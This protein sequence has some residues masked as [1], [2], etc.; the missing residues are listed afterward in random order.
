MVN[1]FISFVFVGAAIIV[2]FGVPRYASFTSGPGPRPLSDTTRFGMNGQIAPNDVE[3]LNIG[4]YM[5]WRHAVSPSQPNGVEYAQMVRLRDD[6]SDPPYDYW[7]PDW[8]TVAAA[9]A[10]NPG[11]LWLIGNEPDHRGQDNCLASEFASRYHEC[12]TFIKVRDPTARVTPAGIVQATPL[13]LHWLDDVLVAYQTSYGL[14]MPVDAWQMHAQILCETCAWGATYPPGMAE[15]QQSEG[16][17]YSSQDAA[18]V[19]IF[20]EQIVAFR[21]WMRDNGYRDKPLIISEFGVLQPS[22]CGYLGGGDVALGNQMVKDFMTGTFDYCLQAADSAI[23]YPADGDRLVQRWAWYSRNARMSEP[24]CTY[25]TS[26]NG[27]L[28][29]WQELSLLTE[30]GLHFQQYTEGL[31]PTPTPSQTA[32]ATPTITPTVTATPIAAIVGHTTPQRYQ[33][34]GD[35][36]WVTAL[37]VTLS[38]TPGSP[39]EQQVLT[40]AFGV[41]TTTLDVLG[42]TYEIG[43]KGAHTLESSRRDVVIGQGAQHVDFGVLLEGDANDDN[44][45]GILDYSLLYTAFDSSQPSSDFNQDGIVDVLDYSLLYTNY[46]RAGPVYSGS[47]SDHFGQHQNGV[48][49][50]ISGGDVVLGAALPVEIRIFA[51]DAEVDVCQLRLHFAPDLLRVIDDHGS[52]ARTITPGEQ[53]TQVIRN[54]VDNK[55]GEIY[56]VAGAGLGAPAATG[57]IVV[58]RFRVSAISSMEATTTMTITDSTIG[59]AGMPYHVTEESGLIKMFASYRINL[60]I[61]YGEAGCL[62]Y[63]VRK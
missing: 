33:P 17:Y 28:Y 31:I 59:R 7:P 32:T 6:P 55:T 45:V 37:T 18:D 39:L 10:A 21:T 53:L 1:R 60:P 19:S 14:P 62:G 42:G 47:S 49:L 36:S 35:V 61:V 12:Y 54:S 38:S 44:E 40:D 63:K 43:A 29:D 23:G 30:F 22:G 11:A 46:D 50:S 3:Q 27:S 4:W 13:R 20:I 2:G 15:Y 16:R 41:F 9:V 34:A 26:A 51:G 5:N 56:F 57:K 24:D 58:A 8:D 52:V 25:I 48:R